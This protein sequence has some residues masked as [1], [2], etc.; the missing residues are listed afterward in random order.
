MENKPLGI[1]SIGKEL[2]LEAGFE[3][4]ECLA[5]S[6]F[7]KFQLQFRLQ[8]GSCSF[9]SLK[10]E[11]PSTLPIPVQIQ[12]LG[13]QTRIRIGDRLPAKK[14]KQKQIGDAWVG[15]D[16]RTATNGFLL[17]AREFTHPSTP[18]NPRPRPLRFSQTTH[19]T[20]CLLLVFT[21]F[22]FQS[23]LIT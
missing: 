15:S 22:I 16:R 4:C 5:L 11:L 10:S 12:I 6:F 2:R 7:Y 14:Q 9:Q 8:N 23:R 1:T 21:Y 3:V 13:S 17:G 20:Y 18:W 19:C